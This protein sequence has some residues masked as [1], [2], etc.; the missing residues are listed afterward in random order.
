MKKYIADG[1]EAALALIEVMEIGGENKHIENLQRA[2]WDELE[3]MLKNAAPGWLLSV[4]IE[5]RKRAREEEA[6]K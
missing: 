5:G 2:C 6:K 3:G 1:T 4:I